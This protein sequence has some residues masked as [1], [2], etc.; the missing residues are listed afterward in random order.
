M[1][2]T[3]VVY[4]R[5]YDNYYGCTAK[6]ASYWL[7]NMTV[8]V[9]R[10]SFKPLLDLL[11]AV[12]YKILNPNGQFHKIYCLV[13]PEDDCTP[14]QKHLFEML[15]KFDCKAYRTDVRN[16]SMNYYIRNAYANYIT[17]LLTTSKQFDEEILKLEEKY[18]DRI[19]MIKFEKPGKYYLRNYDT[20]D[21]SLLIG[22]LAYLCDNHEDCFVK[23]PRVSSVFSLTSFYYEP[24]QKYLDLLRKKLSDSS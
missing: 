9:E 8:A 3:K 1:S 2:W 5:G 7:D 14:Q 12:R 17:V 21:K 10:D 24:F 23:D 11:Y 20:E 4:N 18:L 15:E 19:V 22:L 16:G 6:E 13:C